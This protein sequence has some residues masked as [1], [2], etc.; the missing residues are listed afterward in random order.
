M[1]DAVQKFVSDN[2]ERYVAE[3]LDFLRIPSVSAKSEHAG[4]CRAAAEWI[5]G[6]MAAA[7]LDVEIVPTAG[8]PIVLGEHRAAGTDAPTVLVY[9]H[10][11][12]QPSDPDGLWTTPPFEPDVR[13]VDYAEGPHVFARGATDDKGQMFTHVK[14]A[15]AWHRAGGGLP[16]NVVYVIEGEE[17]VGSN[18]LTPFLESNRDRLACD[19]AVISD[20][21]QYAPGVPA[22]TYGL[23]G[24]TACEIRVAGPDHDLHSGT[25]GGAVTN[26][27][28]ALCQ[29]VAALH[30]EDGRVMI[31]GFYDDV[32]PLSEDERGQFAALPFDET[33]FFNE[34]G[35]S[36]GHGEAGFS[37][38]E[39]RWARP[40]CDVN[41]MLSGYTGEG[42][43][44]IIPSKAMAKV[45]CRLVPGQNWA[46]ITESLEAFLRRRLPA[47][48]E[49]EFLSEHGAPGVVMDTGS[50]FM[51]AAKRA[52]AEAFGSE[53]VFIRE[54]GSIPVVATLK[55][56]L[57]V[58]TL[59]LGWGQNTDRLHAP[60]ERFSLADFQRG[61]AASASLMGRL[62]GRVVS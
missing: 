44:T 11:D 41:G 14:A 49:M 58:D 61:I 37:T 22:I 1:S 52:I 26:P 43:K 15:E 25:F 8:H 36:G 57:G 24:I 4:D 21:S 51:A 20:T 19:V 30:R 35:V 16:V 9:G 3:L 55:D 48:I 42:P 31:P 2:A 46:K 23:R 28:N 62:T 27:A 13:G 39:R 18:N 10:Y 56:V 40:T 50:P 47:G 45:T 38:T 32:V 33:A 6:Q 17:E 7:G 53:P 54:G 12:V 60:D 34:L 59:L 29:L 5:A